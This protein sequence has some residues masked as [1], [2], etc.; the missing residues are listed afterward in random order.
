LLDLI[1]HLHPNSLVLVHEHF[2]VDQFT[3]NTS[4][5]MLMDVIVEA[6]GT[7]RDHSITYITLE[8]TSH[9]NIHNWH[10]V[11]YPANRLR[12]IHGF[13]LRRNILYSN[14]KLHWRI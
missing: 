3:L 6:L 14:I 2:G 9:T 8:R 4:L 5:P 13:F 1:G 7:E 10:V 11:V 12:G